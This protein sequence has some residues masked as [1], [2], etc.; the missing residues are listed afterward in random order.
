M[1]RIFLKFIKKVSSSPRMDWLALGSGVIAYVGLTLNHI[2]SSPIWFDEAFGAYLV[3]YNYLDIARYTATDVHPPLFY[4]ILKAW[5]D[6]F[7]TSELAFRSLSTLFG[8]AVIVLGFLIVKRLFSRRAAWVAVLLLALS[9][10][11]IRYGQEARMYT[12]AAAIVLGATYALTFAI[13]SN[14]RL[15]WA[16]YGILVALGMWTHYFTLFA[17]LAHWVWR[18]IVVKQPGQTI[19]VWWEALFSREW[20]YPYILAIVLFVP[21]A[22]IMLV[23]LTVVQ[24]GGFWIGSVGAY[25]FAN[26]MTNVLFYLE[27]NKAL[28]WAALALA[29][30]VVSTVVFGY[31]AYRKFGKEQRKSLL[32]IASLA[33]VPVV[34][35]FLAS[36]PPLHSSFVE[37]YLLPS[38]AAFSLLAGIIFTANL[39]KARLWKLGTIGVIVASMIFGVS[40][41]YYYGNYNK[42]SDIKVETGAVVKRI[43]AEAKAGE[44]IIAGSP[45]IYYEAVFYSTDKHPVYF[46]DSST[47]YEFGSLDMLKYSDYHKIK[48][49]DEFTKNNPVVWYV[50][51]VKQPNLTPPSDKWK[52]IQS[53][54]IYDN[55]DGNSSYKAAEYQ[56]N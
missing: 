29:I 52:E 28:G 14:K 18:A 42:S 11:L 24:V 48:N 2:T 25:S 45:W 41:V 5:T 16:I 17:W 34:L 21:W 36:M 15:P 27:N 35:L 51:S 30:V 40:N 26:Y 38:I 3:R 39:D 12:M 31:Q 4:W 46:L 33:V 43:L 32:L 7:G 44:P 55:V 54:A 23:Q 47:N 19:K 50:D 8:V 6:L 1:K 56:T 22:I 10:M 9:P 53:F 13:K 37:R 49:L 20:M